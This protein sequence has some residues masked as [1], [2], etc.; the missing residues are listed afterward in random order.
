MYLCKVGLRNKEIEALALVD[1]SASVEYKFNSK[2][3]LK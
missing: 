1:K 2:K 3:G